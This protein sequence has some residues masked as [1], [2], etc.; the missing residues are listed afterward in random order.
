[1]NLL[2]ISINHR[3]ASIELREKVH[4]SHD[5]VESFTREMVSSLFSEAFVISTCNRTELYGIPVDPAT[6]FGAMQNFLLERKKIPQMSGKHFEN[7]FSCSAVNHLFRVSSG[8]DSQL[9]GDNQILGQLK[10]AFRISE[11]TGAAGFLMKRLFDAASRTGKRVKTE[12][13]ISDGAI[14]VSYAAVQLTEKIFHNLAKKCALVIGAGETAEIAAKHLSEKGIGA[15]TISNRTYSKASALAAKLGCSSLAFERLKEELYRFDIIISATGAPHVIL[16]ADDIRGTLKKRNGVSTCI[17]D[18]AVPRDV[19][20]S[21]SLLNNVFYHDLDSLKIIVDQNLKKRDQE[22]PRAK[23]IIEEEMVGFFNWYNSLEAAP[24][25]KS[26][27]DYFEKVRTEEL[28]KQRHRFSE[29]DFEKLEILTSR[30]INKLLHQPTVELKKLSGNS[31][32]SGEIMHKVDLLR[33][34][35]KLD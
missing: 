2:A 21:V 15:L 7:F 18:I 20:S 25:I 11:E 10:E 5:E 9:V 26:L 31:G 23:E 27:R 12:T 8:I 17:I 35:F 34:L 32:D 16:T 22:I 33:S 4:L 14:T 6:G 29:E 1:M 13:I 19:E 24:L 28:E 30:I 3:T